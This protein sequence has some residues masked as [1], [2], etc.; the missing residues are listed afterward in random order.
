MAEDVAM[1]ITSGAWEAQTFTTESGSST[2]Q[3]IVKTHHNP[4]QE[5]FHPERSFALFDEVLWCRR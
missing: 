5:I 2:N 4:L 3:S 1:E